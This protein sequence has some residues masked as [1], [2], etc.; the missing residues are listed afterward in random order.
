MRR[1]M[2]QAHR[3][4]GIEPRLVYARSGRLGRLDPRVRDTNSAGQ[5]ATSVGYLPTIEYANY[6]VPGLALRRRLRRAGV[7]Q[8]VTGSHAMSL[9]PIV[10]RRPFIS[11]VA[12][13]Y[14]DEVDGRI[15]ADHPSLSVR[16]NHALRGVNQALERW[17]Y[18]FPA[19]VF[20]LS[21]YT[22]DRLVTVTDLPR[23]HFEVLRFPVDTHLFNPEGPRW[24]GVAGRYLLA[25]GRVDDE[26]K[27]FP[28]LLRAFARVAP[29]ELD[30]SLV[31]AG[32]H[33]PR[34]AVVRLAG[35]LGLGD[36]VKFPGVLAPENLADVYRSAEGFVMTSRQEGLGIVVLEAQASGVPP[37]VMR[38]G[39]A[40]ELIDDGRTGWLV[41]QGDEEGFAQ[42]L[43]TL[44][45]DGALRARVGRAAREQVQQESSR[46]QFER[47]LARAYGEVFGKVTPQC[48]EVSA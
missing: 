41:E 37:V 15:A 28:A 24:D 6:V 43:A 35:T 2:Q 23:S 1:A 16:L 36:R 34:S 17:S 46:E 45:G 20:A 19:K 27:N 38:C 14:G 18:R 21:Q 44:L 4:L 33:E 42:R 11:W 48:A 30:V 9:I 8:L 22:A 29:R 12:T 32:A 25:V 26:R 47:T 7:V 3:R 13:P 10:A 39:G 31:I 40:D 5:L